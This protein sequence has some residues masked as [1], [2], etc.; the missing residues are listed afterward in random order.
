MFCTITTRQ[1]RWLEWD[2]IVRV[3]DNNAQTWIYA[4]MNLRRES[5]QALSVFARAQVEVVLIKLGGDRDSLLRYAMASAR[6]DKIEYQA[7]RG[8]CLSA[9]QSYFRTSVFQA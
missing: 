4:G 5:P 8:S 2:H 1:Q 9:L 6:G 7:D 3:S